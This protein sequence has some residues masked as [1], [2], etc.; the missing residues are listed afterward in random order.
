MPLRRRRSIGSSSSKTASG[1]TVHPSTGCDPG[2]SGAACH[3]YEVDPIGNTHSEHAESS[4]YGCLPGTTR[5][6]KRRPYTEN[7]PA[8]RWATCSA[9][10]P[11]VLAA[12]SRGPDQAVAYGERSG[13]EARVHL[14]LGEDALDV[15][16]DGVR[17]DREPGR[18]LHPARSLR[19]QLEDLTFPDG[20]LLHEHVRVL[21]LRTSVPRSRPGKLLRHDDVPVEHGPDGGHELVDG[22]VLRDVAPEPQAYRLGNCPRVDQGGHG[23]ELGVRHLIED[24][25]ADAQAA[26]VGE[27]DVDQDHVGTFPTSQVQAFGSRGRRPQDLHAHCFQGGSDDLRE[28]P[29]VVD[30]EDSTGGFGHLPLAAGSSRW[31]VAPGPVDSTQIRPSWASATRRAMNSPSPVPARE[32]LPASPRARGSKM[33][34]RSARGI[35]GPSSFTVSVTRPG[36]RSTQTETGRSLGEYCRAFLIKLLTAARM[37]LPSAMTVARVEIVT[38]TRR[39]PRSIMHD[40]AA[41]LASL[42]RSVRRRRKPPVP[43]LHR[44][45]ESTSS[46]RYESSWFDRR[47]SSRRPG[48]GAVTIKCS[49]TALA[50]TS[51]PRTSWAVAARPRSRCSFRRSAHVTVARWANTSSRRG[52]M[53]PSERLRE[54]DIPPATRTASPTWSK[55]GVPPPTISAKTLGRRRRSLSVSFPHHGSVPISR[56]SC[57]VLRGPSPRSPKPLPGSRTSRSRSPPLPAGPPEGCWPEPCSEPGWL[58]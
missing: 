45:N 24:P 50:P 28:E 58:R 14:Q 26:L 30:D 27:P 34:S 29:V 39:S 54:S 25:L 11:S 41:S 17:A 9:A 35:P 2:L 10:A 1:R 36:P 42:P 32:A 8:D 6:A 37:C 38:A 15:G 46:D 13:F 47:S 53:I 3:P 7:D 43:M 33:T 44:S 52:P 19:Q 18:D 55:V 49:M 20:E 23:D 4:G 51:G 5:G 21:L 57:A 40:S 31:N 16:A 12:L 56:R 22:G 48:S